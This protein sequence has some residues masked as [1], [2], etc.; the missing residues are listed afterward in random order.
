MYT[1]EEKKPDNS[2]ISII[3]PIFNM[4]EYLAPCIE[5]VLNQTFKNI[6]LILVD[7][8]SSDTSLK[9]CN[10]YKENDCRIRV[11][12]KT[13]GGVSSARNYGLK[14]AKGDYFVFLDGDDILHPQ[15]IETLL[16]DFSL[17]GDI[18]ISS[19]QLK[20]FWSENNISKDANN[21]KIVKA[22]CNDTISMILRG[23][24]TSSCARMYSKNLCD[25]IKFE[26]G[27]KYNEDKFFIFS[28]VIRNPNS[29]FIFHSA[30]LYFVRERFDSC[31]GITGE[32]N[33]DT[34]Y[35]SHKILEQISQSKPELIEDAKYNDLMTKINNLHFLFLKKVERK[36]QKELFKAIRTEIVN[37]DKETWKIMK[38]KYKLE[39]FFM[40]LGFAFYKV[41][42]A[43]WKVIKRKGR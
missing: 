33:M 29:F 41:L 1:L 8:G 21:D 11:F 7:D 24:E 34:P 26:E 31:S 2:L 37:Y 13:N 14:N 19:C 43:I 16:D 32:F 12:S 25:N 4:S 38:R 39:K 15:F 22:N 10:S 5:S 18:S 27:R 28:C 3:I 35:F 36:K 9:I 40:I 6:E 42:I 17:F 30:P 23:T 20:S